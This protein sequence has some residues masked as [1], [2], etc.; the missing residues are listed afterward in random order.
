[1]ATAAER[2]GGERQ[3]D[4]QSLRQVAL[5]SFIG[6][7]IEWYDFYL[8]GTAAALVFDKLFFPTF[9]HF[10]GQLASFATF[11]I[12]F[13]AR[14]LGG[15]FFGHYGDKIGRKAMLVATLILMGLSTFLIGAL[16]TYQQIGVAAPLLLIALRFVQ[17]FAVGGEWG[18][19]VLMVV[20]H[21]ENRGR[22]FWGS[23]S[24]SGT[25]VGLLLSI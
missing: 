9:D 18:G 15:V 8:Y 22:G 24:Q 25:S 1:M 21:G 6:T 2:L 12:G 17:G 10:T 13:F 16:P 20:E 14:P 3:G 23:L 19:A 4:T 7:T 11:A 5:A